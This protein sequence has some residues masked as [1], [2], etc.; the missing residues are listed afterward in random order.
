MNNLML[1]FLDLILF[2]VHSPPD[3]P[4]RA[5]STSSQSL[6]SNSPSI[7]PSDFH[8]SPV[9]FSVAF[10]FPWNFSQNRTWSWTG[11][12]PHRIVCFI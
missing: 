9:L 11:L 8:T 1:H 2:S 5:H 7:T 6:Y 4:F 12:T 3:L 10:R